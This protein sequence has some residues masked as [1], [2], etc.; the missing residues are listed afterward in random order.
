[1]TD[2]GHPDDEA[3]DGRLSDSDR[4]A[5]EAPE[6]LAV[7]LLGSFVLLV[8]ASVGAALVS[9]FSGP[10]LEGVAPAAQILEQATDWASPVTALII[11]AAL[12]A[13]WWQVRGWSDVVDESEPEDPEMSEEDELRSAFRYLRRGRALAA[14]GVA[15]LGALAAGQIGYTVSVVMVFGS[16]GFGDQASGQSVRAIGYLLATGLLVGAG[17]WFAL[18]MRADA[19]LAGL[20]AE[21][22]RLQGTT[23]QTS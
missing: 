13:T 14:G 7:A 6:V 19:A 11:L 1:M 16:G 5:T 8:L 2:V 9:A 18:R 3:P 22:H 20:L 23:E 15:M 4:L 10:P 17:M 12:G 21:R